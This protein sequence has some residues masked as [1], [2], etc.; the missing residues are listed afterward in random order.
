MDIPYYTVPFTFSQ[1]CLSWIKKQTAPIVDHFQKNSVPH[2]G[3]VPMEPEDWPTWQNSIAWK[4]VV[5]FVNKYNL[6][7]PD[8]QFFIYKKLDSP[9]PDSRGNPHIDTTV[10]PGSTLGVDGAKRDVPVRFNILL[11]GN[12]DQE[13][14]WW[15][16]DR[17]HP[18]VETVM[19]MR[20]NGKEAARLQVKGGSP[21]G[22]W[23]N[24]GTP[25]WRYSKLTKLNEYASFV[26]T[27]KLHA[28]NWDG[29]NPRLIL[30][31]RFL[32]SWDELTAQVKQ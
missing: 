25:E 20:P 10:P 32:I 9:L 17:N 19:F 7:H 6:P 21:A 27:D 1:E 16:I 24:I 22:R 29:R 2:S 31:L 5:E 3:L 8:L 14:V 26:R 30:T 23:D 11:D 28:I 4:E 13:M 18:L 12:E 15:D